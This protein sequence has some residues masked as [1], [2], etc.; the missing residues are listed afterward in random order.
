[1]ARTTLVPV[2]VALALVAV[3]F[4]LGA[5]VPPWVQYL[6]LVASG[7]AFGLPHGAVDHLVGA[8]V[9][10]TTPA[11]SAAAVTA[12]Y[13]VC[14]LGYLAL[15]YLA[16]IPAAALFVAIT[17]I[18]WGQGD[19][20][21]LDAVTGG[22]YPRSIPHRV[23]TLVVRGALP[24][25][26][27]LVA[28]PEQYRRVVTNLVALFGADPAG[29]AVVFSPRVR[30]LL[31]AAV[32]G[33]TLVTLTRGLLARPPAG[34]GRRYRITIDRGTTIDVV[35]TTLLWAYFLVVP[36][37]L[38]VGLYFCLHHSVRHV[39][40]VLA[41]DERGAAALRSLDLSAALARFS[42][43][44]APLT[45]VSLV[46]LAALAPLVPRAPGGMAEG[47]ALYLVLIAVLTLPHVVVVSWLDYVQS[48]WT[49][50][51]EPA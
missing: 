12:V 47:V 45:G 5:D 44:A 10:A 6:P 22:T 11:R 41:L 48:V 26:L 7:V 9:G 23:L 39:V 33:G 36:P 8:R 38:A 34:S 1:V 35:E 50:E 51:R 4:A 14:G 21:L 19:V 25:A 24:M 32:A 15:W 46:L 17:W 2:W 18:H 16:P 30:V 13:A 3:P 27:P 20:Y 49:P 29:I 42:R 28:A 40:R 37:I 31:A 43:D